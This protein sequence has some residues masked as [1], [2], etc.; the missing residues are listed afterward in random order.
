MC[1]PISGPD[2]FRRA[3]DNVSHN[4]ETGKLFHLSP[5][6]AGKRS[7]PT[8]KRGHEGTRRTAS[9]LMTVSTHQGSGM[10]C[11]LQPPVEAQA[12]TVNDD[13]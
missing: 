4:P 11:V 6:Q 7:P 13:A 1:H 2:G 8:R 3:D 10:V 9:P 12:E 5:K